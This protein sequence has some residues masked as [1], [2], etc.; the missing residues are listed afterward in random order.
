M[1]KD[2]ARVVRVR[3]VGERTFGIKPFFRYVT[4]WPWIGKEVFVEKLVS[5]GRISRGRCPRLLTRLQ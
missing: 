5:A 4:P 1:Q 3:E 2:G